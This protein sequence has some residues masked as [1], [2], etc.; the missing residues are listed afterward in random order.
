[1]RMA[2]GPWNIR[3]FCQ[4]APTFQPAFFSWP[5]VLPWALHQP[6][7]SWNS[8]N[9]MCRGLQAAVCHGAPVLGKGQLLQDLQAGAG[10]VLAGEQAGGRRREGEL[11]RVEPLRRVTVAAHWAEEQAFA[12][13]HPDVFLLE[14]RHHE[15]PQG[16]FFHAAPHHG[17]EHRVAALEADGLPRQLVGCQVTA[18][19]QRAAGA[20][21]QMALGV[22]QRQALDGAAHRGHQHLNQ[23]V[24]TAFQHLLRGGTGGVGV[25]FQVTVRQC[26]VQRQEQ[27]VVHEIPRRHG[28]RHLQ[29]QFFVPGRPGSQCLLEALIALPDALGKGGKQMPGLGGFHPAGGAGEQRDAQLVLQ[30]ADLVTQGGL[31]EEQLPRGSRKIQRFIQGQ[32]TA[33][34]PISHAGHLLSGVFPIVT[35]LQWKVNE[36]IE[37]VHNC[38]PEN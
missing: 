7:Q 28:Q 31:G 3:P 8:I 23:G 38:K 10:V 33:D 6:V 36:L 18:D 13:Q 2:Q 15:P 24:H 25:H 22:E 37:E 32:K 1:M 35:K 26:L 4:A 12:G 34:L 20:Y 9:V 17:R 5:M 19:A 21:Q 27:V 29:H 16:D 14:V 30:T 11:Q